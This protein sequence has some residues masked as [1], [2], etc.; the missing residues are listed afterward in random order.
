VQTL[1]AACLIFIWA[2]EPFTSAYPDRNS[3][4]T[5]QRLLRGF[6]ELPQ[7]EPAQARVTPNIGQ[8]RPAMASVRTVQAKALGWS[9][10]R[11]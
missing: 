3:G 7:D 2:A 10:G 9:F 6:T 5:L 8:H 11:G 1:K 4:P